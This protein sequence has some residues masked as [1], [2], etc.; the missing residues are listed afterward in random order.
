MTDDLRSTIEAAVATA[1]K[2]AAA[3]PSPAPATAP[4]PAAAPA[5]A[6]AAS[7]M[8][9]TKAGEY[10][11]EGSE[12]PEDSGTKP[13]GVDTG[14]EPNSEQ[15]SAEKPEG[16]KKP[17]VP[18]HK[19]PQSWKPGAKAKW[20]TID[21]EVRQDIVRRERDV[22]R[23]LSETARERKFAKDFQEAV[24]PFAPRFQAAGVNPIQAVRSLMHVDQVL[25]SAPMAQR[26]TVMAKMIKDYGIDISVLDSALAGENVS[27]TDPRSVVEQMV[28][29]R[30]RPF[31]EH[32]QT[33]QQLAQQRQQQMME[34]SAQA[35]AEME[36]NPK[37]P[38]FDMVRQDMADYIEVQEKKGVPVTL[39]Q[40]YN[41]AVAMN[42]D[43]QAAL[44]EAAKQSKAQQANASAQRALGAS[45]SVG[46]NP[47]SLRTTVPAT[48]LRG[49]LEAAIAAH[50]GR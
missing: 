7:T 49:T 18:T 41:R 46:G 40:A 39:E 45:L 33:Q 10:K 15:N 24:R 16:E 21:P 31:Q 50:S 5:S 44:Q 34:Q 23:T 37:Y 30:L 22:E 1:D 3:S 42:D 4:A 38:Y 32:L 19:P 35:V 12:K 11:P 43:A 28:E 13:A 17:A 20:E 36:G 14:A 48:D 47:A 8:L 26:A 25:S 27:E 2:A 29:Q 9:E 6:P